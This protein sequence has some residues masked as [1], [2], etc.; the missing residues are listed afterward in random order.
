[1]AQRTPTTRD[2]SGELVFLG[3]GTSVGVPVVGCSCAVCTSEDPRNARLRC[4]VVAGLP[5][6]NLLVDT[7][8]DLRS[9]LLRE[10]LGLVHATLFT[11]GHADHIFG[12]DDLRLFPI[13]LGRR[14][15]VYGE[16]IVCERIRKSFDYAFHQ[17]TPS[18]VPQ[19]ELNEITTEPFE[20]LG[21][22]IT[23]IRLMHGSLAVLGFRIGNVA[24][25]TDTN[26]V[27]DE[28]WPR[29]EGLDVLVLDALR[30]T[31]HNTH[32]NLAQAIEVAQRVGAK[33][34]LFTH[35]AHELDHE[36]TNRELP[37]GMELAF[38]GLRIPLT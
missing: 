20:L 11:H 9:Q 25:C 32:F 36:A 1:M 33:R 15:P 19:L 16:T 27:P 14:L 7:P 8:P 5:E 23:P 2:I 21:T 38:D 37:D 34:T 26:L 6:G 28:S 13:Y 30:H 4:S 29:L 18:Y 12:L 22:T 24:Y 10:G 17:E 31:P 35:I 3:T